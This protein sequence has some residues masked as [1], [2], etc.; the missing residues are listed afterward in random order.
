MW[1]PNRLPCNGDP[2]GQ[3]Q[4]FTTA[5]QGQVQNNIKIYKRI[6]LVSLYMVVIT[7]LLSCRVSFFDYTS[8]S[9][10]RRSKC[11]TF[12]VSVYCVLPTPKVAI[13]GRNLSF[14]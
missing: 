9:I 6:K 10:E 13:S 2:Q 3:G 1:V 14:C 7:C 8:Y 4:C 11:L 5:L 12:R